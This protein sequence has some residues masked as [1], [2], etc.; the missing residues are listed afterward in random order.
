MVFTRLFISLPER[1]HFIPNVVQHSKSIIPNFICL[2]L[3]LYIINAI[4]YQC[5][6][7]PR[8]VLPIRIVIVY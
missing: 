2:H 4:K 3:H 1:H 7:Y 6:Y 8:C 5:P